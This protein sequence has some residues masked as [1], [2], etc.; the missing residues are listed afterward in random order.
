MSLKPQENPSSISSRRAPSILALAT[1]A[2]VMATMAPDAEAGNRRINLDR[3]PGQAQPEL[4]NLQDAN[5]V[6][7]AL[8]TSYTDCHANKTSL[9]PKSLTFACNDFKRVQRFSSRGL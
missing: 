7:N 1:A 9:D 5:T 4:T 3:A 8:A 2:V 6:A